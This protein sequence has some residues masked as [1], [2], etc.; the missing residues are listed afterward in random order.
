MLAGNAVQVPQGLLSSIRTLTTHMALVTSNEVGGAAY[1][2]LFCA[3]LILLVVNAGASIILH[4]LE[5][6]RGKDE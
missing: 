5:K 2:S 1:G 6:E 3:G 4:A